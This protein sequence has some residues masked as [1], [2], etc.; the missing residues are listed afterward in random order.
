MARVNASML[1]T[2]DMQEAVR[3][4]MSKTKATFPKL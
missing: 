3:A 1:F 2:D 4:S